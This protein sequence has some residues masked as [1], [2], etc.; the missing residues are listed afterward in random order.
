M[1]TDIVE[2]AARIT[3]L[4]PA[5]KV[6]QL[7]VSHVADEDGLWFFSLDGRGEA[8]LESPTGNCPF[9][10]ESTRH[11]RCRVVCSIDEAVNAL[12]AELAAIMGE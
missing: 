2:I 5:V 8:Q 6:R 7:R 11:P 1:E 9:L 12:N 4:H 3:A 10:L